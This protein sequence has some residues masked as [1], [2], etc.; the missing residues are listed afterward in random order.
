VGQKVSAQAS[1]KRA[2]QTY[3]DTEA[4]LEMQDEIQK[5]IKINTNLTEEVHNSI[6]NKNN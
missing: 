1:D 6:V 4:I 2:L 5:L 3:K